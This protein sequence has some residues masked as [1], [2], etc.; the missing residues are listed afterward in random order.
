MDT[1]SFD[2]AAEESINGVG[3]HKR[4]VKLGLVGIV[5]RHVRDGDGG[6]LLT[7]A[8]VKHEALATNSK[9]RIGDD[10]S[11]GRLPVSDPVLGERE[12]AIELRHDSVPDERNTSVH[13]SFSSVFDLAN[14]GAL[15]ENLKE[16]S[17]ISQNIS[18]KV[19]VDITPVNI[20]VDLD[21][22][23]K[24]NITTIS[25]RLL[26]EANTGCDLDLLEVDLNAAFSDQEQL[27]VSEVIAVESAFKVCDLKDYGVILNVCRELHIT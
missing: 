23:D 6:L 15:E 25:K 16:A 26:A 7:S 11:L 5:V 2:Q 19:D 24:R 1:D 4:L 9:L 10:S 17:E 27:L 22:V 13:R 18:V 20:H 14:H 12:V 21:S 3:A 8:L